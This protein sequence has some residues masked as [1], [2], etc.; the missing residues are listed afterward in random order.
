MI[1]MIL[2]VLS[3]TLIGA[4]IGA[5]TNVFAIKMLFRPFRPIYFGR[6]RLPFT[7]GLIPKRRKELALQ[8][9]KLVVDHLLTP[10]GIAN[11]WLHDELKEDA[12]QWLRQRWHTVAT[13]QQTPSD[14]VADHC[15]SEFQTGKQRQ[16]DVFSIEERI[17]ILV[18]EWTNQ[19]IVSLISNEMEAD[20][21]KQFQDWS[22]YL[23]KRGVEYIE[24]PEGKMQLE[25]VV[26]RFFDGKGTIGGLVG[27]FATSDKIVEWLREEIVRVLKD[28]YSIEL[29]TQLI[30]RE[31]EEIRNCQVNELV[32][33]EAIDAAKVTLKQTLYEQVPMLKHWNQPFMNW[34]PEY[35][36]RVFKEWTPVVIDSLFEFVKNRL[37]WWIEQLRI[38]EIVRDQVNGFPLERLEALV[39]SISRRELKMITLF[40]A[41]LGG[42][43]AA[44]QGVLMIIFGMNFSS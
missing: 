28:D 41:L 17:D 25:T 10:E 35:E 5:L 12:N 11:R 43:I 30:D 37:E 32:N 20:L 4:V 33:A 24:S 22:N 40:G 26:S 29:V 44:L 14:W 3:M 18:D 34:M 23:L 13:S 38:D 42:G 8:L 1:Q 36:E 15:S 19:P 6:F 2:V 39:L 16:M 31:Y 9:G 27:R 7:P 21:R